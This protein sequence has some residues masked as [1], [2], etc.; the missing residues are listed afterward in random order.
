MKEYKEEIN[1][2]WESFQEWEK[3]ANK[4]RAEDVLAINDKYDALIKKYEEKEEKI[5]THKGTVIE[6]NGDSFFSAIHNG[7]SPRILSVSTYLKGLDGSSYSLS[8]DD[9]TY[10][11]IVGTEAVLP[12]DTTTGE[13]ISLDLSGFNLFPNNDLPDDYKGNETLHSLWNASAT[14]EGISTGGRSIVKSMYKSGKEDENS[15]II[16]NQHITIANDDFRNK[17]LA[18]CLSTNGGKKQ[19]LR[20]KQAITAFAKNAFTSIPKK[21]EIEDVCESWIEKYKNSLTCVTTIYMCFLEG[22]EDNGKSIWIGHNGF[23]SDDNYYY[24]E[25]NNIIWTDNGNVSIAWILTPPDITDVW[26]LNN[27]VDAATYSASA[28]LAGFIGAW[29]W[30]WKS[31]IYND[32]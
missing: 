18:T 11:F 21:T 26:K 4:R 24:D 31:L 12:N 1:R 13:T 16:K 19:H 14:V 32:N 8:L 20:T 29:D 7:E 27:W 17:F 15:N 30:K 28:K 10:T 9:S 25:E 22:I 6:A 3:E 5:K 23:S 2:S